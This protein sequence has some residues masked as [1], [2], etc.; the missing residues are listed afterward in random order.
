MGPLLPLEVLAVIHQGDPA[1]LGETA[2][3]VFGY[4]GQ[5]GIISDEFYREV[6]LGENDAGE[7]LIEVQF[8]IHNWNEKLA[9]GVERV[10]DESTTKSVMTGSEVLGIEA[11]IDARFEWVKGML[12]RLSELA[13]EFQ[14]YD[15]LSGCAHVFP[16]SQIDKLTNVF[17]ET[18]ARTGDPLKAVDMVIT[19]MEDDPGWA[20]GGRREGYTIFSAKKPRDPKSFAEAKTDLERREA[21]CFCPIVRSKMD[22]GMPVEYCYCGSG[23]F[24]QQWEGATGKPVR[25]DILK[26]VLRGNDACEF[27]INLSE[28]I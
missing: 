20:E 6:Y 22:Q 24:R 28:D 4:A 5:H 10:F 8:V 21:Y 23:W 16:Q 14:T 15:I 12:T 1:N 25:I 7:P 18:R 13:D 27:A 11:G 9:G 3:R 26:I 2:G 17:N 19:F